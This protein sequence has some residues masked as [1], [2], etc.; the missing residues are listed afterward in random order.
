MAALEN[1][2]NLSSGTKR[3]TNKITGG[4]YAHFQAFLTTVSGRVS[5]I[6]QKRNSSSGDWIDVEDEKLKQIAF[7]TNNSV[8]DGLS[9][10]LAGGDIEYS[11]NI[12]VGSSTTG[13]LTL[14]V[15]TDG[16]VAAI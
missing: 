3:S 12:A 2:Y 5:Y 10:A 7:H 14:D 8:E 15:I 6:I 4:T 1:A 11:V 13:T 16:T 9:L